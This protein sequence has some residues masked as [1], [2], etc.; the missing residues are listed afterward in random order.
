MY[1]AQ[2]SN[3]FIRN[4]RKTMT[5]D[6]KLRT[7]INHRNHIMEELDRLRGEH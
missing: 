5:P 2:G 4:Y 1:K 3:V 6:E 7:N